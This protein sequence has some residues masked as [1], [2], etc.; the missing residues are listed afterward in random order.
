MSRFAQTVTPFP[1]ALATAF[2]VVVAMIGGCSSTPAG[3]PADAVVA[4]LNE[5][6]STVRLRSGQMLVIKLQ[7]NPSTGYV[8]Q[9]VRE[10][11]A[12]YLLV[13]G[14]KTRQSDAE[15][16]NESQIET[17][18]IRFVAQE[19]GESTVDLNYVIPAAG[20]G[21]ETRRYTLNLVIE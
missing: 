17:Q 21:P 11:N 19:A 5:N 14:T 13:D 3:I 15:R 1:V 2:L 16:A 6:G 20:P 10:P 8:W 4:G 18:Y 7:S 12:R 9:L